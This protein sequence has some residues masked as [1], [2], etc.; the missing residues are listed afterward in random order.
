MRCVQDIRTISADAVRPVSAQDFHDALN[1]VRARYKAKFFRGQYFMLSSSPLHPQLL[2]RP[3]RFRQRY[4]SVHRVEQAVWFIQG[5]FSLLC[6]LSRAPAHSICRLTRECGAAKLSAETSI[7]FLGWILH[8]MMCGCE[9]CW[10][11][12]RPQ[13][14]LPQPK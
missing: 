5:T 12:K 3:Q 4:R 11:P 13:Q 7:A 2:T 14:R 9:I 6:F 8:D 1:Q 10:L